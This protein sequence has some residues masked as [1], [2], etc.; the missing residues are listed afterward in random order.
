MLGEKFIRNKVKS[1]LLKAL[2]PLI[3]D[4]ITRRQAVDGLT[5]LAL[6]LIKAIGIREFIRIIWY[7]KLRANIQRIMDQ[8]SFKPGNISNHASNDT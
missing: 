7:A 3:V 6:N 5:E 1:E 4:P 8:E 2:A